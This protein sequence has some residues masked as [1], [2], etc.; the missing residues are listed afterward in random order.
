MTGYPNP[1]IK[2]ISGTLN[3]E[4]NPALGTNLATS[5]LA[6]G[7]VTQYGGFLG[8]RMRFDAN[9]A[10]K[11]SDSSV[12]T[13]Y[14]GEYQM[15]RVASG[16]A[17]TNSNLTRGRIVFWDTGVAENLYQVTNDET[18]NGGA[19]LFAGVLIGSPTAGNYCFIQ[20]GGRATLRM[21]ATVTA[22][23]RNIGWS[24]A[25]SGADNATFDG[26]A[27]ATALTGANLYPTELAIGEAVAANAG[28]VIA[29][30]L[31]GRWVPR[32]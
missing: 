16:A 1:S 10:L 15:V 3:S 17:S 4:N 30:M 11:L 32:Y 25:G 24:G 9:D 22:A 14:G 26:L 8:V 31:P 18:L 12:G 21:R 2:L 27:N 23:T 19:P 13:L 29:N 6:G 20:I 5:G 7:I 28:L